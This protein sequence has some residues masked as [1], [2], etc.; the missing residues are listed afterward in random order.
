MA[1]SRV[2]NQWSRR[3]ARPGAV[4]LVAI[5]LTLVVATVTAPPS[6]AAES[7]GF[8]VSPYNGGGPGDPGRANFTLELAPGQTL[9]DRV[10]IYNVS[11]APITFAVFGADAYNTPVDGGFAVRMPDGDTGEPA[12]AV[13]VGAWITLPV[14]TLVVPAQSRSDITFTIA[15]PADAEPGDHAGGIVAL[16]TEARPGEGESVNIAVKQALGVRV[17]VRVAGPLEPGLTVSDVALVAGGANVLAPIAGP[18]GA[19]ARYTVTNS[20]NVRLTPSLRLRVTDMFGREVASESLPDLPEILP[21]ESVE[22]AVE[23]GRLSAFGPRYRLAVVAAAGDVTA[24]SSATLWVVPWLLFAVG[25]I[26]GVVAVMLLRRR[27]RPDAGRRVDPEPPTDG[28][29]ASTLVG[30]GAADAA[31]SEG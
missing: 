11:D 13:D 20:G 23:L 8:A 28:G 7:D 25:L 24:K 27:R 2:T 6:N 21:G 4:V 10:S 16:N 1:S 14:D 30:V 29:G 17:Y 22:Q 26:A 9:T 15:V 18:A 19:R 5:L 3:T 12:P 31:A